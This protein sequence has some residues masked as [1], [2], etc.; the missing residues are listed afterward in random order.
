MKITHSTAAIHSLPALKSQ[1]PHQICIINTAGREKR[2]ISVSVTLGTSSNP[3]CSGIL[4]KGLAS[5]SLPQL[6][7]YAQL[8]CNNPDSHSLQFPY[9]CLH[10]HLPYVHLCRCFFPYLED[11]T[12][13]ST[14][15]SFKE[16]GIYSLLAWYSSKVQ[17]FIMT[18]LFLTW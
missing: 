12:H 16:G 6:S 2:W 15:Y 14:Y 13:S 1:W 17:Q 4:L 5:P 10:T 11:Q 18:T 8:R 3:S 7:G 9:F